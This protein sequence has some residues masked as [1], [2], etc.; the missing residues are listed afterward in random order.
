M[1]TDA[2]VVELLEKRIAYKSKTA[3]TINV[4][5]EG[6]K[7]PCWGLRELLCQELPC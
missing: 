1:E 6:G 3:I 2:S 4:R 7:W 5:R